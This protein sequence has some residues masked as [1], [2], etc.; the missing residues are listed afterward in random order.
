MR[1]WCDYCD[2][3]CDLCSGG[4]PD[5]DATPSR[6]DRINDYAQRRLKDAEICVA[7]LADLLRNSEDNGP[8]VTHVRIGSSS[9]ALHEWNPLCD[10]FEKNGIEELE[11]RRQVRIQNAEAEKRRLEQKRKE[12]AAELQK[13]EEALR[14]S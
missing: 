1:A 13:T 14:R 9:L 7:L 12:L 5:R 8:P 10:E 2:N 3:G 11:R 4:N 6:D